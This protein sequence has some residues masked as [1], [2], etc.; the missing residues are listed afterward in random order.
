MSNLRYLKKR[1]LYFYT[2]DEKIKKYL[3]N[4]ILQ[5]T[6]RLILSANLTQKS[7]RKCFRNGLFGNRRILMASVS[8]VNGKLNKKAH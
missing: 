3:K 2:V 7:A 8:H 4:N 6:S 5:E 1:W